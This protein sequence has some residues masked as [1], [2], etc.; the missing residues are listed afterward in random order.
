MGKARKLLYPVSLLYGGIMRLRN[1]FYDRRLFD[2]HSFEVPVICVG[3]LSVGGTGKSPMVEYLIT[4]LK[5][6]LKVATLSRGYKRS[7]SG[8]H[9]LSGQESA[10]ETGDEPLQ[11]KTKFPNVIV[12]VDEKRSRGINILL[13][14]NMPPSVILLDDAF[15][16]RKVSADLNI[17]LTPYH[18]LYSDD[19]VLPAGNLREPV[20]GANRAQVIVVTKCPESLSEGERNKIREKLDIKQGQ[21]LYFS[22]VLYGEQ[23]V[24]QDSSVDIESFRNKEFCLVT[25]IANPAPLV[26]HLKDLDLKFE[27]LEFPDHHNFTSAELERI[28]EQNLLL[29]T[30]KDYMRL[31]GEVDE[32]KL[33][34]LPIK[35]AFLD[36]HTKFDQLIKSKAIKK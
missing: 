27:H 6:E 16:H 2:S 8:F 34:Y 22:K 28:N 21:Q 33:F 13:Q 36:D 18:N 35:T 17:L 15:Q 19:L 5:D 10:A 31:K 11:F 26:N 1:N 32:A 7:T 20:S 4:L 14:L 24:N 29:T 12:A 25:G 23:A 9:L 3:N 30:E